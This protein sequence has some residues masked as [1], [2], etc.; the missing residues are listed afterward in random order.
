MPLSGLDPIMLLGF[1]CKDWEDWED[2]RRRVVEVSLCLEFGVFFGEGV[3][4]FVFV[5]ARTKP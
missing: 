3:N 2:F 5:A 1:L 4:V